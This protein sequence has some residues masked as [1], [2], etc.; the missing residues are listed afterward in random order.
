[1]SVSYTAPAYAILAF[2]A[3]LSW[4]PSLVCLA[5][6]PVVTYGDHGGA[7]GWPLGTVFAVLEGVVLGAV[8]LAWWAR[9][10]ARARPSAGSP[11][12]VPGRPSLAPTLAE[13]GV[14]AL[15]DVCESEERSASRNRHRGIVDRASRRR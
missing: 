10:P 2:L 15:G 11:P 9:G 4:R 6:A 3:G 13:A 14:E 7:E 5:C 1:M 12:V 8:L